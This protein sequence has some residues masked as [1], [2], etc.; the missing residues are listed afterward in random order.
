MVEKE[1]GVRQPA[2]H[3]TGDRRSGLSRR[4]GPRAARACKLYPYK[5]YLSERVEQARPLW[6]PATVLLGEI[7]ER[8]YDGGISQF[9]AWRARPA[10]RAGG[11]HGLQPRSQPCS[12]SGMCFVQAPVHEGC[13]GALLMLL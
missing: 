9:K 7:R 3:A 6:I 1:V 12:E 10:A 8:G 4:F 5:D 2:A 11:H 13:A